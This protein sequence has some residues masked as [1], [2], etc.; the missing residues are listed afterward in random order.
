MRH[1]LQFDAIAVAR[2]TRRVLPTTLPA[3]LVTAPR[4]PQR[5]APPQACTLTHPRSR[6]SPD[7]RPDR[8]EPDSDSERTSTSDDQR[9]RS[10]G[11]EAE[12][13]ERDNDEKPH[14]CVAARGD[15]Q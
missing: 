11:R 7:R 9:P 4:L 14:E 5:L 15:M 3:R 12:C 10:P 8:S 1:F 2:L 13:E 6:C